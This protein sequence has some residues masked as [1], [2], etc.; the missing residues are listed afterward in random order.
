MPSTGCSAN[1]SAPLIAFQITATELGTFEAIK[2]VG[3]V[4]GCVMD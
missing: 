3:G 1:V 4:G 2:G